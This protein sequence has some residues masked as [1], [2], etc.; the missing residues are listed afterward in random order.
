MPEKR[1]FIGISVPVE[2]F[3]S[4]LQALKGLRKTA[5]QREIS[6]KWSPLKN[7][8]ITLSFLGATDEEKIPQILQK[9]RE[10][11]GLHHPIALELKGL[12]GFPDDHHARVLWAGVQNS[13][14][15]RELQHDIEKAMGEIGFAG[16]EREYSPHLTLGRIRK[17]RSV[18]DM[19]SPFV[20][21]RFGKVELSS[22]VLFESRQF[23]QHSV[24]DPLVS[25]ELP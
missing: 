13:R 21:K 6:V 24:Y 2:N 11:A 14:P 10:V 12:G 8:H 16:E 25:V 15:L 19:I 5:D 17:G 9:L 20:R 4:L 23:G 1:L 22:L 18:K 3:T 7:Y